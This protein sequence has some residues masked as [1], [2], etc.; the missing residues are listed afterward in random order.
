VVEGKRTGMGVIGG[1][2]GNHKLED[3]CQC[4]AVPVTLLEPASAPACRVQ[5][6][7]IL[8]PIVSHDRVDVCA[9]PPELIILG[10]AVLEQVQ[11]RQ[12]GN[13]TPVIVLN[14]GPWIIIKLKPS[15]PPRVGHPKPTEGLPLSSCFLRFV[16][17]LVFVMGGAVWFRHVRLSHRV[18]VHVD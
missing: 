14:I 4:H 9:K 8:A 11:P 15:T 6:G 18:L 13:N 3:Q 16:D 5:G 7:C 17:D 12:A 2:D 10:R 1:C